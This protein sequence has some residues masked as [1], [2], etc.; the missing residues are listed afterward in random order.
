MQLAAVPS[1]PAA[2]DQPEA[3]L[4]HPASKASPAEDSADEASS[5]HE[6]HL[7]IRVT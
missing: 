2:K 1:T 6:V 7:L 4:E 5:Q 3:A